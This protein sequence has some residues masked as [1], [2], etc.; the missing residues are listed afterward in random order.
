MNKKSIISTSVKKYDE[1]KK[2][3]FSDKQ[4]RKIAH[5]ILACAIDESHWP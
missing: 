3:G 2:N 1:L 4:I 5:I